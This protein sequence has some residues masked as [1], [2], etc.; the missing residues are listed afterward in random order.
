MPIDLGIS[1]KEMGGGPVEIKKDDV[2]YP[3]VH[4]ESDEKIDFPKEGTMLVEF[5][6]ISSEHRSTPNGEKYSCTLELRYIEE[7]DGEEPETEVKPPARGRDTEAEDALD[8]I[9]KDVMAKRS[10]SKDY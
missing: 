6:K 10:K 4:I 2:H 8:S 7:I 9:A 1:Y 5:K 3:T